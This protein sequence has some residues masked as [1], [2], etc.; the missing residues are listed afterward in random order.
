M[1]QKDNGIGIAFGVWSVNTPT[2]QTTPTTKT[3]PPITKTIQDTLVF[4]WISKSH[5]TEFSILL[6]RESS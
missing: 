6:C 5:M 1:Q 2:T 4:K 3:T